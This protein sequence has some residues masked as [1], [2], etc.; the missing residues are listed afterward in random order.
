MSAGCC[1]VQLHVDEQPSVRLV[2]GVYVPVPG[3][4]GPQG[5]TGPQGPQGPQGETG[6]TGPQGPAGPTGATGPQG[7]QGPKGD[8]FTYDDFTPEQLAALT[9]PQGPQGETGPKG[10]TGAQ[11]P[12][13]PQGEAGADYILTSADKAEIADTVYHEL[14][15]LAGGAY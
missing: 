12:Q 15:N 4:Q 8:A 13:G 9:G 6:A 7:Q 10:D 2:P 3:P 11:G 1:G 14:V 5:E